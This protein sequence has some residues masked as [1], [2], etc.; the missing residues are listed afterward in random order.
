MAKSFYIIDGHA[1]I[2]RAFYAPFREL[3]SPTGEPTKATYVFT[4]MLLNLIGQRKPEYLAMVIDS[5][6]EYVFRKEFYPDYKANRQATPVDLEPQEKR[7][8][9]IVKDAGIPVFARKGFEADDLIATMAKKLCDQDWDIV[10]V[11]KDK[12]LRQLINDCTRLYDVQ[13]DT[14]TDAAKME[15]DLGYGPG[16][17]IEVQS[18]MGDAIDN[19]P[20]IPGVGEKTAAKLIKKYGKAEAVLEHLDELTPKLRE[21]FEKFGTNIPMARRLVTLKND[22]EF[23]FDPEACRFLGVDLDAIKP[24][25]E[26]LGFTA[27]LKRLG[28]KEGGP[29]SQEDVNV[30]R[31]IPARKRP[32]SFQD[33]LFGPPPEETVAPPSA[34]S[35]DCD[36][37]LITTERD[38]TDFLAELKKQKRFA[39]DTETDA[40]G[41]MNSNLIGMSFSWKEAAGYYVPVRGPA[42][43][44]H[45]PCEKVLAALKAV[46]EDPKVG[47][48]GHNIK[49]DLLVMRNSGI[50]LRGVEM[51]T[52]IAAFLLDASRMQ[53]GIDQLARDLLNFKKI[54]TRELIGREGRVSMHR[55]PLEQ[56]ARY[57]AEDAD[58][59]WRMGEML[60]AK[61]KEIPALGKLNDELETPLIDVVA[62]MEFNGVAID[63]QILKQQSEVLGARAEQLR[64]EIMDAA[65]CNFNPDS[66]KQ[67]ADVLFNKLGLKVIKKNKTGPSTDV[68]VL[69]RLAAEHKCP[70]LILEYRSLV[71]LKN[72]YLDNLTDYVNPRTNRIHASFNQT[73]AA[74]GRLSCSDPNLQNIPIR[75]DEGRRIR[76]AFVAGGE[77]KVLLTADYS[78]I[79]LRVLAHFTEEPALLRAFE[80]DED[81]HRAVA[82]EVFNVAL[83]Q[84]SREQRG[85]AKTIN[86]GIIYGV[87]AMGLARR[88][89]G[90]TVKTADELINAYNRRF[91][92]ILKFMDK[93]V[94]DA[95]ANGYVETI[96]GRRRRI[97]E[98][99]SPVLAQRNAGERMAINSVVQGSAA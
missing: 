77:D 26:E 28:L 59:A 85:Q 53:F 33:S 65:G 55:L 58:V 49:Y 24:H 94:M 98:L 19:V 3:S 11:S 90:M 14:F 76:L 93:C 61:M 29:Q 7:I 88:I 5:G 83:D 95:Q 43:C 66:T 81:I 4:Q 67:L 36:Y 78:Q 70:R 22:V 69:E 72:T 62:E 18:L 56:V 27:L 6:D 73:G 17:A 12:D 25:L 99:A 64:G 44:E 32:E 89:E 80:A 79:E 87:S 57:A 16:E 39:F 96:M 46:L 92:S 48:I 42:G 51:D 23:E 41:A 50:N 31:R 30:A 45:L 8:L 86:F 38:F 35:S 74:T 37:R 91:P 97:P 75:T 52:M 71:K 21:N 68:M 54:A 84:V 63:A 2:F 10:V 60:R 15:T 13:S 1:Q 47:K 9:Q 40:L 82:A 20:G 34:T